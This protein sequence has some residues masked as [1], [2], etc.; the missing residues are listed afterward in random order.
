MNDYSWLNEQWADLDEEGLEV[1]HRR[2]GVLEVDVVAGAGDDLVA[3][4]EPADPL[5]HLRVGQLAGALTGH[6]LRGDRGERHAQR[7][8]AQLVAL[9]HR[10]VEVVL[11]GRLE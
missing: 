4:S 5:G 10:V 9:T 8:G 7:R 1:A 3:G 6:L 2:V 11:E